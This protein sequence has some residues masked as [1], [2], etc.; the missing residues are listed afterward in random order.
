MERPKVNNR[1]SALIDARGGEL[2]N[3]L[4]IYEDGGCGQGTID[5]CAIQFAILFSV[6]IMWTVANSVVQEAAQ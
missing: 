5:G 3:V 2:P 4:Y 1:S 6:N